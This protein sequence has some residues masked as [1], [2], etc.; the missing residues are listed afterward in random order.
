MDSETPPLRDLPHLRDRVTVEG[1][2]GTFIVIA[3]NSSLR[4]VDL[5]G[6]SQSGYL[7][8]IHISRLRP[9]SNLPSGHASPRPDPHPDPFDPRIL[10]LSRL[11]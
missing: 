1:H 10:R 6:T 8:G 2:E 3:C 7:F 4:E 5:A 9:V 11:V